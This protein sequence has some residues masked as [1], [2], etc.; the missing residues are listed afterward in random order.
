M[1]LRPSSQLAQQDQCELTSNSG[2]KHHCRALST[3]ECSAR[4]GA[5]EGQNRVV[6]RRMKLLDGRN[7]GMLDR[8]IGLFEG[9][10][11]GRDGGTRSRI[12]GKTAAGVTPSSRRLDAEVDETGGRTARRQSVQVAV[13]E[14]MR[15]GRKLCLQVLRS[16]R[17]RRGWRARRICGVGKKDEREKGVLLSWI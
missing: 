10:L 1:V 15:G 12:D 9:R 14:T 13:P 16:P 2:R 6:T 3:P 11:R 8:A 5:R 17:K 7:V 4:W